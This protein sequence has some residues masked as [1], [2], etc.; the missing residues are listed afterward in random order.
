RRVTG[1]GGD[2]LLEHLGGAVARRH[3]RRALGGDAS[4]GDVPA[5]GGDRLDRATPPARLA[6]GPLQGPQAAVGAVDADDDQVVAIHSL[7]PLGYSRPR[8]TATGQWAWW[9]TCLATDPSG[10]PPPPPR[11]RQ[12]ITTIWACSDA[13]MRACA[14]VSA[15]SCTVTGTS[16]RRRRHGSSRCSTNRRSA[17]SSAASS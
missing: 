2:R 16:G 15:T 7:S 1:Q 8:I 13:A 5:P 9:M 3:V 11:P 12:P 17:A 14:G 10:W 4:P 6:G